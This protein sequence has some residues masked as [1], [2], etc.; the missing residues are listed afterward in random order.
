[1]EPASLHCYFFKNR[2]LFDTG[3][4]RK[5]LENENIVK[6]I[7]S[8]SGDSAALYFQF[9]VHL[10]NVFDTQIAHIVIQEHKGTI[11]VPL[12]KLEDICSTYSKTSKVSD[13]KE[14]IRKNWIKQVGG[15]R[16]KRPLT[17]EMIEYAAGDVTSLIPEVYETQKKFIEENDLWAKY[18]ERIEEEVNYDIDESLR[19]KRL[20]RLQKNIRKIVDTLPQKYTLSTT[21]NDIE[22][23]DDLQAI[24]RLRWEDASNLHPVIMHLKTH[25]VNA[26]LNE[27]SEQLDT[28]GSDFMIR[29]NP[30]GFLRS[31]ERHPD[32]SI[33]N[34]SRE[35]RQRINDIMIGDIA[36]KYDR[37]TSLNEINPAEKDALKSLRPRGQND[38]R[39]NP[40]VLKLYWDVQEEIVDDIARRL[41]EQ[42]GDYRITKGMYKRMQF[43][44]S[45][46]DVPIKVKVKAK[47]LIQN[48]DRLFGRGKIPFKQ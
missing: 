19:K 9:K 10:Q 14:E 21:M 5:V 31:L 22:D 44:I 16:A 39:Y 15:Y 43:F 7:H 2:N 12:L 47:E 8:C 45:N 48:L 4:L 11:L 20:D 41:S 24:K 40:V 18:M 29:W 27:L 32:T 13:Q 34:R 28:E 25:T 33:Q 1:M 17:D 36:R 30:D 42:R 23:D 35:V 37:G 26:Q 38:T 3:N 6:V 46:M